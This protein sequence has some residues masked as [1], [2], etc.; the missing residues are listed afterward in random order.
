MQTKSTGNNRD[1]KVLVDLGIGMI[2]IRHIRQDFGDVDCPE[3]CPQRT[4]EADDQAQILDEKVMGSQANSGMVIALEQISK[5][6]VWFQNRRAKWRR[7][8][9]MEAARL[10]LSEYNH[11]AVIRNTPAG[12]GMGLPGDPWLHPPGL[13]NAL[14]GFL[15][16]PHAGYASYLTSPRRLPSPPSVVAAAAAAAAAGTALTAG[17]L[18]GGMASLVSGGGT[19]HQPPAAISPP[20]TAA[21]IGAAAAHD[22]RTSSIHTLRMRAKEHEERLS[23]SGRSMSPPALAHQSSRDEAFVPVS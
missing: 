1:P 11:V 7:Q 15:A 13:L 16:G 14:P 10:G 4:L 3:D 9:K 8:E 5:L 6:R 12:S 22:P 20:A 17:A 18:S 21:G 23:G 2:I 19:V